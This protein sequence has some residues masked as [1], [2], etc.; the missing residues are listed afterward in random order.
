[1]IYVQRKF[2][3]GDHFDLFDLKPILLLQHQVLALKLRVVM[4]LISL[5]VSGFLR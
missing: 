4:E 3:R 1:M 2:I 5:A